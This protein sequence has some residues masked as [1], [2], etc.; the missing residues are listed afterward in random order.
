MLIETFGSGMGQVTSFVFV[1]VKLVWF[2][3]SRYQEWMTSLRFLLEKSTLWQ[4]IVY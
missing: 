2:V 4:S 3:F 1:D